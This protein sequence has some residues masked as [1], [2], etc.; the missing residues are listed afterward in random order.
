MRHINYVLNDKGEPVAERNFEKWVLW[1]VMTFSK[2][3]RKIDQLQER[4][5]GSREQAMAMHER[6]ARRVRDHFGIR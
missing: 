3:H 4:C 2:R 1:E 6:M 5:S